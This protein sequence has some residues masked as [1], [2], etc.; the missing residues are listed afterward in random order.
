MRSELSKYI[1]NVNTA[2]LESFQVLKNLKGENIFDTFLNVESFN[3][4]QEVKKEVKS[5]KIKFEK[6]PKGLSKGEKKE[7]R[8]MR[9][10]RNKEL[11]A[12]F[13]QSINDAEKLQRKDRNAMTKKISQSIFEEQLNL[14][15]KS[16]KAITYFDTLKLNN[17][18]I[19]MATK[20]I[21]N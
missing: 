4:L 13:W 5:L 3:N 12:P 14:K 8:Q 15:Q 6:L 20:W 2:N 9:R 11:Q 18:K 16:G 19:R 7:I 10:A 17:P 1:S 21:R